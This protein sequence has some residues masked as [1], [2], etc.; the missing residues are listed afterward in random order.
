MTETTQDRAGPDTR[1][2]AAHGR[3]L[4]S[5][6]QALVRSVLDQRR[7]DAE[8]GTDTDTGAY[9]SGYQGSPL[10][11]I[12]LEFARQSALLDE[13]GIVFRPGVNEELAATAVAGS[14]LAAGRPEHTVEGVL[15]VWSCCPAKRW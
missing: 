13:L 12:D 15:G 3:V 14:Q 9:V 10:G 5:G 4:L 2:G 1:F 7:A 11:T 6:V 8:A